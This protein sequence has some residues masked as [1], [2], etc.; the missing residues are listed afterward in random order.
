[1]FRFL[2]IYLVLL[3]SLDTSACGVNP[4]VMYLGGEH[5]GSTVE[6]VTRGDIFHVSCVEG[7]ISSLV[8]TDTMAI[9]LHG[10]SIDV[11]D[12]S[13]VEVEDRIKYTLTLLNTPNGI[14]VAPKI[15]S[16]KRIHSIRSPE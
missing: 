3:T 14:A 2:I 16:R 5:S 4:S 11:T 13:R 1:M 6:V 8:V 12:M 15:N 7:F 9:E 10:A